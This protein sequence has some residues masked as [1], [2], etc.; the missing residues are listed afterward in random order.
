VAVVDSCRKLRR[1][2]SVVAI[3]DPLTRGVGGALRGDCNAGGGKVVVG[4]LHE[5]IPPRPVFLR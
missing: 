5:T 3:D 1:D 4:R 2:R